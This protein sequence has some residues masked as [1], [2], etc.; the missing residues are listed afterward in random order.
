MH[1]GSAA[2][3]ARSFLWSFVMLWQ[4][5][6]FRSVSLWRPASDVGSPVILLVLPRPL[7]SRRVRR[8]SS[9]SAL[10]S[11][12]MFAVAPERTRTVRLSI[13]LKALRS[14]LS[15]LTPAKWHTVT[16]KSFRRSLAMTREP[17]AESATAPSPRLARSAPMH[18]ITGRLSSPLTPLQPF[19]LRDV[20]LGSLGSWLRLP[21]IRWQ[22]VRSRCAS[23]GSASNRFPRKPVSP[24][25]SATSIR[26]NSVSWASTRRSPKRRVH[27]LKLTEV[28]LS[29]DPRPLQ[30]PSS[31]SRP[32]R[33]NEARPLW[34]MLRISWQRSKRP[35]P[36]KFA[37]PTKS[38]RFDTSATPLLT[39]HASTAPLETAPPEAVLLVE[40]PEPG[41]REPVP[42]TVGGGGV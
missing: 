34:R 16:L 21:L 8:V 4:K 39:A 31:D 35:Q 12:V 36:R 6:R 27:P 14:P 41:L 28:R 37:P 10:M 13:G 2:Q 23:R 5:R 22:L 42:A 3:R 24:K 32:L 7:R 15:E 17:V 40:P 19:K 18:A 25:Q 11:P 20:R 33:S 30:L 1:M 38:L 9:A 26:S 29:S